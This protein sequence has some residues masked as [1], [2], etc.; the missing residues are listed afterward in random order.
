MAMIL[1]ATTLRQAGLSVII[2]S[3]T[4]VAAGIA[5]AGDLD[6]PGYT[7]RSADYER[8]GERE[9]VYAPAPLDR[10]YEV[11]ERQ[12]RTFHERRVDSYGRE[13]IHRIRMCDEGPVYPD[14]AIGPAD[15]SYPPRPYYERS[16][17]RP[18]PR[19]PAAI[20]EY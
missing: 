11:T 20:G 3:M 1:S 2:A 8:M 15:Y 14:R 19:P 13:V 4:L 17:Y 5:S 9:H 16:G 18:Y 10:R 12:C 6:P 7:H